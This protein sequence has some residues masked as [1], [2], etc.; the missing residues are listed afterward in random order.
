HHLYFLNS[1]DM[2]SFSNKI[3][4]LLG[5]K[6]CLLKVLCRHKKVN[7][8]FVD[9]ISQFRIIEATMDKEQFHA[10]TLFIEIEGRSRIRNSKFVKRFP[11]AFPGRMIRIKLIYRPLNCRQHRLNRPYLRLSE[12]FTDKLCR[13]G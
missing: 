9:A 6:S 10:E 11:Y 2:H 8:G 1:V 7:M 12:G 5:L 4:I 13:W 3:R